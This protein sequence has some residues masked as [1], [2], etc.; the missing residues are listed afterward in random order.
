MTENVWNDHLI[1]G[2]S[3]TVFGM[4]KW[5]GEDI[6]RYWQTETNSSININNLLTKIYSIYLDIIEDLV[7]IWNDCQIHGRRGLCV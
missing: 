6:R 1:P 5:N 3:K 7:H 4:K 2:F